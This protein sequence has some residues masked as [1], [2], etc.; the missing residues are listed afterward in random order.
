MK[1]IAWV[2]AAAAAVIFGAGAASAGDA[3]KGAS[4]FRQKGCWQCHGF[5]GQGGSA[6]PRLA[7]TQLPEDGLVSFVH[8]TSGAM[9]PFSE[10]LVS[11][12]ELS[13]IYAYLQSRPKPA[14]PK[15]IPL[16]Q[17]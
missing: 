16:L 5:E 15:S 9:P 7:N 12:Q 2:A 14:D 4:T 10:K 17:P 11:D 3:E 6:G 13:D 8:G 1:K